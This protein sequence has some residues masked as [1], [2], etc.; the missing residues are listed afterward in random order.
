MARRSD[1]SRDELREMALI[2]AEFLLDETP[3][4]DIS[5]RKIATKM[6]YT[7]GTL[8]QLYD[9]LPHLL[10][11]VNA[12]T[13]KTLHLTCQQ[14][15]QLSQDPL[16]NIKTYA[17]NYANFSHHHQGRWKLIF[18]RNLLLQIKQPSWYQYQVKQ[19]FQLV[20]FELQR[21]SPG[22]PKAEIRTTAYLLWSSIHGICSMALAQ[23]EIEQPKQDR[24]TD[25]QQLIS[26]L[27]DNFIKGWMIS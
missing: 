2:A 9:N 1:H 12:R 11:H 3:A 20:E 22:K 21:L 24:W 16:E 5:T 18:D 26:S 27:I 25:N 14:Q 6:G 7:V 23:P 4:V 17:F 8:Y 15:V 13:L 19:L 10:L